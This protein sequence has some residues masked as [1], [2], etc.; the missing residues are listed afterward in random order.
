M[1]RHILVPLDG[2][3]LA[4]CVLPHVLALAT[5]HDASVTVLQVLEPRPE[6]SATPFSDPLDLRLDN[7]IADA[8]LAEVAQRLSRA[9]VLVETA[10]LS[11]AAAEQIVAFARRTDVDLIVMSSH[12]KRGLSEWNVSSVT[13]KVALRATRSLMIVRAYAARQESQELALYHRVLV[14]LDGSQRAEYVLPAA[15]SVARAHDA[16]LVLAHIVRE[17]ERPQHLWSDDKDIDLVQQLVTAKRRTAEVYLKGLCARLPVAAEMELL[18]ST[19]VAGT[20]RDLAQRRSCDLV[21]LSAHGN[22]GSPLCTYGSVTTGLIGYGRAPLLI[23]QDLAQGQMAP[24]TAELAVQEHK[25][26]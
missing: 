23:V 5:V 6:R 9:G 7:V 22:S 21:M 20:L 16:A 19:D 3:V 17:P 15:V 1:F 10:T 2:S 4:E 24:L 11:G 13:Q 18:T 26:H 8:Y 12:G 14:P 25:G